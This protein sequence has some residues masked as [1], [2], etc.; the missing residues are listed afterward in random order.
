MWGCRVVTFLR[1]EGQ[2][3]HKEEREPGVISTPKKFYEEAKQSLYQRKMKI[4]W[5]SM[6]LLVCSVLAVN[7][8]LFQFG[9]MIQKLTGK[10][11][12]PHYTTYG[13]YCGVGGQGKPRDDTD[14]CCLAHDCCYEK[15]KD[16]NANTDI[17]N[18]SIDDGVITCGEGS[19]CEKQICECD[20]TA[21]LCLKDHL[22]TYNEEYRFYFDKNC[23]EGPMK[24]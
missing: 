21:A 2:P 6:V 20:K 7:G 13:C 8:N 24:C 18:Y 9:R 10:T 17:Y 4:L 11:S 3:N 22:D 16:C 5:G 23:K 14:R 1:R 19:S 15:L 12:F